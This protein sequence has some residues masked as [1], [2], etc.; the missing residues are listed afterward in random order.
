MGGDYAPCLQ[1][2]KSY[3]EILSDQGE[4]RTGKDLNSASQVNFTLLRTSPLTH[5]NTR[6][7]LRLHVSLQSKQ[8]I[9]VSLFDVPRAVEHTIRRC[10]RTPRSRRQRRRQAPTYFV[11]A[12]WRNFSS[13]KSDTVLQ[14]DVQSAGTRLRCVRQDGFQCADVSRKTSC[15]AKTPRNS[16][17]FG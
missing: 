10:V 1:A 5:S 8:S 9:E 17:G 16:D 7:H 11:D 13:N 12:I 4:S 6:L 15:S 2:G 3:G 14:N